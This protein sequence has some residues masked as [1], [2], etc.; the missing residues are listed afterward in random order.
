MTIGVV[1]SGNVCDLLAGCL[2]DVHFIALH[3]LAFAILLLSLGCF[4]RLFL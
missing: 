3:T 4:D 1:D 2:Q